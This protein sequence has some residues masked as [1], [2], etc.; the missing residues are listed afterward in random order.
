LLFPCFG[1]F[2]PEW[3]GFE[4]RGFSGLRD[5]LVGTNSHNSNLVY[6]LDESLDEALPSIQAGVEKDLMSLGSQEFGAIIL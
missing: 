3:F 2:W 6:D 1:R 4:A 5:F